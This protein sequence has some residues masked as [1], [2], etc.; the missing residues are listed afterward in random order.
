MAITLAALGRARDACQLRFYVG[1]G[2]RGH[3]KLPV[4]GI[5]APMLRANLGFPKGE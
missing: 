5:T 2:F 1:G 3:A 4:P